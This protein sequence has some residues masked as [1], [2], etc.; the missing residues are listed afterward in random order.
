MIPTT[1][2]VSLVE[3]PQIGLDHRSHPRIS[4]IRLIQSQVARFGENART[5][6]MRT[7]SG[8][9]AAGDLSAMFRSPACNVA[10]QGRAW[11]ALITK[12][13]ISI[14]PAYAS[15]SQLGPYPQD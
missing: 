5:A 14:G 13:L 15:A 7:A 8:N 12:A 11:A 2:N 9:L 1:A 10:E 6:G 3:H 4:L